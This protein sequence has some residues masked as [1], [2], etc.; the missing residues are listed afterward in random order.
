MNI[1]AHQHFWIY[2]DHDYPWMGPRHDSIRKP[3]LP[4]DLAPLLDSIGFDGSVAVQARRTI[5]ETEWLLELAAVYPR[6]YGVVGWLDLCSPSVGEQID[7]YAANPA[8][9]GVRHSVHDDPD[10]NFVR[11]ADF[12]NG[13]SLL[14]PAGLTYDLIL[15]PRHLR[16]AMDL[17]DSFPNQ[18][19]VIDHF[20]RPPIATGVV[21]PWARDLRD[22]ARRDN[23]WCKL[24]GMVT[25]ADIHAWKADDFTPYLEVVLEAFGPNRLMIGSDWPVCT[26]AG[27]Y[28]PVMELVTDYAKRLSPDEQAAILGGTAVEF[29]GITRQEPDQTM[30]FASEV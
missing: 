17:V 18:R 5:E 21:E 2:N 13:V 19:F 30:Y 23:V 4:D 22:I 15:F 10:T 28:R 16:T 11:R 29:Y 24:S 6:I 20:A 27:A 25:E 12:Q 9:V 14:E 8:F 3:F 1:D 7:H 26:L